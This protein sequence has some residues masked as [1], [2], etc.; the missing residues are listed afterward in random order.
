MGSDKRFY[1]NELCLDDT[2]GQTLASKALKGL[3]KQDEAR[4]NKTLGKFTLFGEKDG[5]L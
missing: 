1:R 2:K 4:V 5:E 3:K